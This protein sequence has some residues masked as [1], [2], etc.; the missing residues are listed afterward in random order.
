MNLGLVGTR[1]RCATVWTA[2][3]AVATLLVWGLL[4]AAVQGVRAL[5]VGAVGRTG[6]ADLLVWA[7]AVTGLAMTCWLWL[8]TSA[9]VFDAGRGSAV[10]RRGVP[11]TLR[12][13][14]LVLCGVALSGSL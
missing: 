13:V 14:V 3:T 2:A 12:R 9:V 6:F 4:P 1:A 10:L 8:L 7:C 11:A 5:E